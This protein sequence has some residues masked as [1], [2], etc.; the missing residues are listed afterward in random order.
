MSVQVPFG[1]LKVSE[2]EVF[3]RGGIKDVLV[4]NQVR[5]PQKIDLL[6]RMPLKGAKITVCVD[7]VDNVA[8]L[9]AAA[10][11]HG[12]TLD[13]FIEIDG[14]GVLENTVQPEKRP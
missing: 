14:I 10:V 7:D 2:A 9:S 11:K 8:D 13:C 3:V 1:K 5:S 4:S 6:A 12:T